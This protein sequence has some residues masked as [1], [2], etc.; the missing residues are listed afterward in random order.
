[1]AQNIYMEMKHGRRER[2]V[3]ITRFHMPVCGF[4]VFILW[5]EGSGP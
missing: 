3:S 1:M 2:I 5:A 4:P